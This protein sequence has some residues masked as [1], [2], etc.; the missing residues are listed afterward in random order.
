[1][2]QPFPDKQLVE[3]I[4]S[5][6]QQQMYGFPYTLHGTNAHVSFSPIPDI[7]WYVVAAIPN[8]YLYAELTQLA[9]ATLW[10]GLLC[11]IVSAMIAYIISLGISVPS[12]RIVYAMNEAQQ[13]NLHIHID[14][15]HKDEM[16]QISSSFNV[17]IA[18]IRSLI[19]QFSTSSESVLNQAQSIDAASDKSKHATGQF[20]AIIE[21]IAE[22]AS[23]Q[24]AEAQDCVT[25]MN[26][27]SDKMNLIGKDIRTVSEAVRNTQ[28]ASEG[29]MGVIQ[30]LNE[31]TVTANAVSGGII[32]HITE[33]N[34]NITKVADIARL[35]SNLSKQTNILSINASIEAARAG[36]AG[37]G[38]SVVAQE[39]NRLAEQSR[40]ASLT[41]SGIISDMQT[42]YGTTVQL[43]NQA[44]LIIEEQ[45]EA[46]TETDQTF[47]NI[48]KDMEQISG[49]VFQIN[50]SVNDI[51]QSKEKTL[52]AIEAI[53]SVA[54]ET[55]AATEE[56][57]AGTQVQR[58]GAEELAGL[59]E[60]L[61]QTAEELSKAISNFNM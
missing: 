18:N 57:A 16:G 25:N 36:A 37:R 47:R 39:V 10:I 45:K 5:S 20:A 43:T 32:Q 13:G 31:K 42:K 26:A 52:Q 60:H 59:A 17:M 23:H 49:Y 22:G 3:K 34:E 50:D 21:Q 40:A 15:P 6:N 48:V 51:L 7:D 58:T 33:F 38:F 29:T 54:K 9:N 11:L 56:V 14:D 30:S 8:S 27:L 19:Q 1:V 2:N 61:H 24:A 4:V 46:V 44:S 28:K 12:R 35:I 55:A 53:S 41:I